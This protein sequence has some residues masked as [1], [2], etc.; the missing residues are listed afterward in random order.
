MRMFVDSLREKPEISVA[1]GRENQEESLD[2]TAAVFQKQ[3][4]VRFDVFKEINEY[5]AMMPPS[6]QAEVWK[7]YQQANTDFETALTEAE[8]FENLS[9]AITRLVEL[10]PIE[11]L[12]RFLENSPGIRIPE[13]VKDT[14][15]VNNET[16]S[17]SK[18]YTK[19]DYLGL[20]AFSMLLRTSLPIVGEYIEATRR[21]VGVD[22]KEFAAMKLFIAS[23]LLNHPVVQKLSTYINVIG[24]TSAR[25]DE[26]VLVGK[27]SEDM[28]FI[29]LALVVIRRLCTADLRGLPDERDPVRVIYNFVYQ[30]TFNPSKKGLMFKK[31]P[32]VPVGGED[33]NR[34]IMEAYRK[35]TELSYAEI[36]GMEYGYEDL[37]G[38]ALRLAPDISEEFVLSCVESARA[39]RN[40]PLSDVQMI[41]C[42]W[43]FKTV[44]SYQA[45]SYMSK[46][47]VIDNLGVLQA[48]LWQWGHKFLACLAT[49]TP[50]LDLNEMNI[51]SVD[52]KAQLPK[53]LYEELLTHYPYIWKNI[54]RSREIE[55]EPHPVVLAIDLLVDEIMANAW[56]MTIDEKLSREVFRDG[57]RK[58]TLPSTLRAELAR[59]IID[60]ENRRK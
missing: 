37:V 17:Q 27:S 47:L 20:L 41:L 44:H 38:T 57:R 30:S 5:W 19:P 59:L 13:D 8:L 32:V 31:K 34:T 60:V 21:D 12:Q 39:L 7:I 45:I 54:K 3:V 58:L 11:H 40:E 14:F 28:S 50:I 46:E 29:S 16:F 15:D 10:H 33:N 42:S 43:A 2:F 24:K 55:N 26:L 18:T 4:F 52:N 1:H 25:N 35:R 51:S 56:K 36:A 22:Y 9:N 23:G 48:V 53:E 6:K 49:A